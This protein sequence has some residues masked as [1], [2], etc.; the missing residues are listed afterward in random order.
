MVKIN[1]DNTKSILKFHY[2]NLTIKEGG[3][4]TLINFL[5]NRIN[6]S[7]DNAVLINM[8][9]ELK[10]NCLKNND[11]YSLLTALPS[12]LENFKT[13]FENT[14]A[15]QLNAI[16]K[17]KADG[18]TVTY[19]QDLLK[20]FYY[21]DYD[22]WK[23]YELARKIKVKVC[24]YCNRSFTFVLGNDSKKGTRFEYD[25][26]YDKAKYPYLALSFYNLVPSCHICNS[27]FKGDKQFTLNTNIHP[28]IQDFGNDIVFS[29]YPKNINF[30]NGASEEYRIRIIKQNNEVDIVKYKKAYK[31]IRTFGLIKLYNMHK[32]YVNEI[33][34]KSIVYN[35]DHIT[36]LYR[37]YGG[38]LFS[39]EDDVKRMV[40]GNYVNEEEYS[41]R[42]LSKLTADISKELGIIK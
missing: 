22:K 42:P 14:Y 19:R 33:I 15:A 31:N 36:E 5:D 17:T 13:N 9:T 23:S 40:L 10:T 8:Y 39:S 27:N 7:A 30:I 24:P 38:T 12:E 26:F 21:S 6:L 11:G 18:K 20:V 2:D 1:L 32:D 4:W 34:L 16:F 3:R 28:Y 41:K 25:H 35:E 29:I 37:K